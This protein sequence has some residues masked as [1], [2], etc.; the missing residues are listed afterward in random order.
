MAPRED[1]LRH[2][3]SLQCGRCGRSFGKTYIL[4]RHMETTKRCIEP[5]GM[6]T[7]PIKLGPELAEA[8][9]KLQQAKKGEIYSAIEYCLKYFSK[10]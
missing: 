4:K 3:K 7:S 1:A 8:I 10:Y 5:V 9:V 6:S 2:L